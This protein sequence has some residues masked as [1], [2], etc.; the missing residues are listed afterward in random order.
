MPRHP[1]AFAAGQTLHVIQRGNNRS[2]CFACDTDRATYLT[3]LHDLA[4]VT[5]NTRDF[6][7]AGLRVV[8]P[9]A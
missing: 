1:R 6:T 9:F 4:V 7:K 3:M 5:R 2:A 8:D